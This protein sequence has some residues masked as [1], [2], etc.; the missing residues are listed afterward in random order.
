M[1]RSMSEVAQRW[2]AP[3]G[4]KRSCRTAFSMSDNSIY[5]F[6]LVVEPVF[7]SLVGARFKGAVGLSFEGPAFEGTA[8]MGTVGC[9]AGRCRSV[10]R[11]GKGASAS[12][13][14]A[15]LSGG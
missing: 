5:A 4:S 7:G 11:Q 3:A 10:G 13:V 6:P 15:S 2:L 8:G 12:V 1:A 14:P 9:T